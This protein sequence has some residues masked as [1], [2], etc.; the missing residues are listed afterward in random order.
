MTVTFEELD[1]LYIVD[2]NGTKKGDMTMVIKAEA[3]SSAVGYL[4]RP[5]VS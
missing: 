3:N 4:K 2:F 1:N 5:D